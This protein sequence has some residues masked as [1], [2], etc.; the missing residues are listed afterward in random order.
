MMFCNYY[1]NCNIDACD[2]YWCRT[3]L[4]IAA[5]RN[6]ITA[7]RI[8]LENNADMQIKDKLGNQP[9]HVAADGGSYEYVNAH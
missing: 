6:H 3:P 4:I 5:Y 9:I 2:G 7:V 1:R 8:F